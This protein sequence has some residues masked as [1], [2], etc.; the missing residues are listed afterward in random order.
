MGNKNPL[1]TLQESSILLVK[2]NAQDEAGGQQKS[3]THP[4]RKFYSS[5]M[6]SAGSMPV[7]FQAAS[8]ELIV[9]APVVPKKAIPK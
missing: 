2:F 9:A 5:R 3:V 6:A 4:T 1:P 8:N 7:V